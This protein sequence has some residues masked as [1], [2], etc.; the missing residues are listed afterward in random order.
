MSNLS[1]LKDGKVIKVDETWLRTRDNGDF[2]NPV[3][4]LISRLANSVS[5]FSVWENWPK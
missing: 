1:A 5:D 3:Q 4:L 2:N